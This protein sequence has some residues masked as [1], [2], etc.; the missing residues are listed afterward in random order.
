[1]TITILSSAALALW[2]VASLLWGVGAA[3]ELQE[4]QE[5]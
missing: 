5:R 2:L 3:G 4:E 1:M